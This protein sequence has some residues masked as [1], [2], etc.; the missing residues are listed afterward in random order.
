M[1]KCGNAKTIL[2]GI[3]SWS[4]ISRTMKPT[5]ILAMGGFVGDLITI[6]YDRQALDHY[7]DDGMV[8]VP[9]ERLKLKKESF[10]SN[11]TQQELLEYIS[12]YP[13]VCTQLTHRILEISY[14][15]VNVIV[16]YAS[17]DKMIEYF[18]KRM[19]KYHPYFFN[20]QLYTTMEEYITQC[21]QYRERWPT[22]FKNKIDVSEI[23]TDVNFLDKLP[24][25]KVT[26]RQVVTLDT[27]QWL[28][29]RTEFN[30]NT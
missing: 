1:E 11:A 25:L 23:H 30:D 8:I 4:K 3:G 20:S 13:V 15:G 21:K 28:N 2:K 27:W 17:D 10:Y 22:L 9:E 6:L 18:A 7:T 29:P 26:T 19:F 12:Q 5:V 16:V 24:G 14:L